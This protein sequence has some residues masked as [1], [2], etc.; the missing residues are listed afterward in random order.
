MTFNGVGRPCS[1]TLMWQHSWCSISGL[2]CHT[3]R[4]FPKPIVV[5]KV[6]EKSHNAWKSAVMRICVPKL[7]DIRPELVLRNRKWTQK[8]IKWQEMSGNVTYHGRSFKLF[9]VW[10][11]QCQQ[12]DQ[13][14]FRLASGANWS[15]LA[16]LLYTW[17]QQPDS[18]YAE[19]CS[20]TVLSPQCEIMFHQAG[21]HLNE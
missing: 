20:V 13:W 15:A 9:V 11:L 10:R 6:P 21:Q 7:L 18:K 4:I 1:Q 14:A 2:G 17:S 19:C 3:E 5:T 12:I 8:W 16:A